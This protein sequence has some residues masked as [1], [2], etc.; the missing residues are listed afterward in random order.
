MTSAPGVHSPVQALNGVMEKKEK[1]ARL[2]FGSDAGDT[3]SRYI[4][5][6]PEDADVMQIHRP[7]AG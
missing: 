7:P 4:Y 1:H 2:G 5:C 6:P 3:F